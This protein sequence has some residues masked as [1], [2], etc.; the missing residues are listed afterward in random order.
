MANEDD[1]NDSKNQK[2]EEKEKGAKVVSAFQGKEFDDDAM[3]A[4][5]EDQFCR[6]DGDD[7]DDDDDDVQQDSN[8]RRR[9]KGR[10][11]ILDAATNAP[12]DT[13]GVIEAEALRSGSGRRGWRRR[14]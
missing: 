12:A 3:D 4:M 7:D 2:E 8:G 9:L 13:A 5:F 14:V 10:V 1:G 11:R 6:D